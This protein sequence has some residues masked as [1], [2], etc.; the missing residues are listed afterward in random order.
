MV[1]HATLAGIKFDHT[2]TSAFTDAVSSGFRTLLLDAPLGEVLVARQGTSQRGRLFIVKHVYDAPITGTAAE[3]RA[4]RVLVQTLQRQAIEKV[5]ADKTKSSVITY[6]DSLREINTLPVGTNEEA[7]QARKTKYRYYIVGLCFL[8]LWGAITH[9]SILRCWT[10]RFYVPFSAWFSD[11]AK[12]VKL[13]LNN[14]VKS[15]NAIEKSLSGDGKVAT[16]AVASLGW[17]VYA[18]LIS[19]AARDYPYLTSVAVLVSILMGFAFTALIATPQV[20]DVTGQRRV[21][22]MI[23]N[24]CVFFAG[25]VAIAYAYHTHISTS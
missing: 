9:V 17:I 2:V 3:A 8:G 15:F 10:G 1:S 25:A 24:M 7:I 5:V 16:F 21:L 6:S 22:V 19:L 11:E 12:E 14:A 13:K 20:L 4:R 18:V 23:F